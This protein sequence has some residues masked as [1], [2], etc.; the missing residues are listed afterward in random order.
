M[1]YSRDVRRGGF[2]LIEVL[3]VLVILVV[4]TSFAA[5]QF[6]GQQKRAKI[7]EAKTQIGLCES[8]IQNFQL[9]TGNYPTTA[10][11][12]SALRQA[13]ADLADTTKWDGPYLTKD[14]P[15][16]PWGQTYQYACPGSHNIDSFDIWT[17][18][19]DGQ[20]IGNW[21]TQ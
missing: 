6:T 20:E 9:S 18:G 16:D 12:L 5:V 2:T 4:L 21:G 19:P 10:Q 1:S 15:L 14:V 8:A 7:N 17:I 11:G 13:P 3:L